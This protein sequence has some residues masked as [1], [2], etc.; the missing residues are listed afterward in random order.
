MYAVRRLKVKQW[1]HQPANERYSVQIARGGTLVSGIQP[2]R[3]GEI[4]EE[5]MYWRKANHIHAWFVDNVQDGEDDCGTHI[6]DWEKLRT[7]LSQCEKVMRASE[8]VSGTI[9]AGTAYDQ[10]RPEGLALREPGKVIKDAT[11]AREL[12]PTRAG[13]FFGGQEYDEDYLSDVVNTRDW[14]VSM[15]ADHEAG[16]PGDIY[17]QSSW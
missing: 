3:I 6:V 14:I 12:L 10:E 4:E 1:D 5:V 13:F 17:Y 8:L 16:V 11:V 2:E 9:Y 7:L 15:L